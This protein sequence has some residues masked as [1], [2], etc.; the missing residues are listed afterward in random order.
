M[1]N[2]LKFEIVAVGNMFTCL[3][4]LYSLVWIIPHVLKIGFI[5]DKVVCCC[6]GCF[7]DKG[8]WGVNNVDRFV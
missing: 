3:I 7:S 2:V 6:V 5:N 4:R 1:R 8:V